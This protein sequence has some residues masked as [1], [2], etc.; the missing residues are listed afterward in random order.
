LTMSSPTRACCEY[1]A[2]ALLSTLLQHAWVFS[3]A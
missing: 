2:A 3:D 1:T